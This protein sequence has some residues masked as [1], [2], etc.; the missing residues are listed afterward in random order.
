MR[1]LLCLA[2]A[3]ISLG[4]LSKAHAQDV[5]SI[6]D[7]RKS[8]PMEPTEPVYHDYYINAGIEVGLKKGIYV[9]IFRAAPVHDPL[10][11]KA[12]ANIHIPVGKIQIIHAEK[13]LSVARPVSELTDEERPTLE[14]ESIMI[15]DQLDLKT[16]TAEAPK[17]RRK[18][19]KVRTVSL[20]T[21]TAVQVVTPMIVT[22]VPVAIPAPVPAPTVVPDKASA[23]VTSA[24]AAAKENNV[25]PAPVVAP[26]PAPAKEDTVKVPVPAPAAPAASSA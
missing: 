10:Q 6:F 1:L 14:Y 5:I 15:G 24:P 8:L 26:A 22:T 20:D 25:P 7:L 3:T 21:S 19:E 23:A 4:S 13:N 9:D 2:M 18:K 17:E 11:N 16:A 12:Q